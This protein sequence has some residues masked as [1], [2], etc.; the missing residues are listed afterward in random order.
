MDS[1]H[2]IFIIYCIVCG[3]SLSVYH[4]STKRIE[5]A[6]ELLVEILELCHSYNTRHLTDTIEY[7]N[8]NAYKWCYDQ[9]PRMKDMVWSFKSIKLESFLDQETIIKLKTK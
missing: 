6:H 7:P 5:Q 8:E 4:W 1:I 3:I 9:V 2:I